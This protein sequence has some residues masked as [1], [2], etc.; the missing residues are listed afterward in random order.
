MLS[1]DRVDFFHG[2]GEALQSYLGLINLVKALDQ[3][4]PNGNEL[5][6]MTTK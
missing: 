6:L 1:N 3:V 4:D 2:A 5:L